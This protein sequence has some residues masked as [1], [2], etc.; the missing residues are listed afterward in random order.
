MEIN[1]TETKD[2][3]EFFSVIKQNYRLILIFISCSCLA[4]AI[5]TYFIP[6]QYTSSAIIYP[7]FSNSLEDVIRNPQFGSD[8]EADRLLQLLESR[9]I[10]DSIVRKFDLV[11]Y[12]DIDKSDRDWQFQLTKKFQKDITFTKTALM[13][14]VI[15]A[16]SRDPEM[17]A[18][19]VN[20]IILLLSKIRE[21]LFKRN[22]YIALAS[23]KKEFEALKSGLDSMSGVL[24]RMT[25][26]R[27]DVQQYLQTEKYVSLIF[28]KKQ[29]ADDDAG[30]ALQLAVNQYNVK[31]SWLYDVQNS[32][33]YAALMSQR[34]LPSVYVIESAEPSYNKS[35]PNYSINLLIAFSGSS[36]FI[37]FL[38]FLIQKIRNILA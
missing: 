37:S 30:K 4:V 1:K 8:V 28:D 22:V 23:F 35:Y 20:E 3:V 12:Y 36:V 10:R 17:S 16:R 7:T 15:S 14:L 24:N 19:V 21:K 9:S 38:L 34:P 32:L 29:M 2:F 18:Q 5:G 6:R 31:L 26:T 33:K 27:K 13:S 11:K 25:R